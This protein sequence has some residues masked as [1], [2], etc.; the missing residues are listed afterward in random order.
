MQTL[1]P[2]QQQDLKDETFTFTPTTA[3]SP[4]PPSTSPSPAPISLTVA[5]RKSTSRTSNFKLTVQVSRRDL[6][7]SLTGFGGAPWSS[8]SDEDDDAPAADIDALGLDVWPAAITLCQYL[9]DTPE[10]VVNKRVI[11]LGAGVGLPGM[12]AAKLGAAESVVS[13][14]DAAVVG[15]AVGV[16]SRSAVRSHALIL[17]LALRA[18][19]LRLSARRSSWG[20][21]DCRGW[22]VLRL[23]TGRSPS[24]RGIGTRL[25]WSWLPTCCT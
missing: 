15:H 22:R 13:D 19:L 5:V 21:V 24:R 20:A 18:S 16:N 12:V 3:I 6:F 10:R 4:I 23:W 2:Q 9:V 7:N 25:T 11:E 8:S 17:S 14:Y 1:T